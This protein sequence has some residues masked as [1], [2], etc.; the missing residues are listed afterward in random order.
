MAIAIAVHCIP[1]Q[2]NF[3][4]G[5]EGGRAVSDTSLW[6]FHWVSVNAHGHDHDYM[7]MSWSWFGSSNVT[8]SG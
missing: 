3:F 6:E 2:N 8:Y 5:G 7:V 1:K 4:L